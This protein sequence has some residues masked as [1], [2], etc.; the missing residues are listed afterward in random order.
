MITWCE[1]ASEL[2]WNRFPPW[3]LAVSVRFPSALSTMVQRPALTVA[4]Q[5]SGPPEA[6]TLTLPVGAP[7]AVVTVN[8]TSTPCPGC[9][10]SGYRRRCCVVVGAAL[11]SIGPEVTEVKPAAAKI[12]RCLP[13]APV[14]P[15]LVNVARPLASV[16]C[17]AVPIKRA[18]AVPYRRRH[19]HAGGRHRVPG[20][21]AHLDHG[22]PS[23]WDAHLGVA[24]RL[25]DDAERR[26][27]SRSRRRLEADR[28]GTLRGSLD[29][30]LPTR[31]PRVHAVDARPSLAVLLVRG[32]T[33][34]PPL[35]TRQVTVTPAPG[36]PRR[37]SPGPPEGPPAW[38]RPDHPARHRRRCGC[39]PDL[40]PPRWR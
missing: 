31:E 3:K 27:G 2:D 28:A 1:S 19:R 8:T 13:L 16:V 21:V 6:V 15:R 14:M 7:P 37:R 18:G 34:P 10:G 35:S 39:P 17:V 22:L 38:C 20:R 24:R 33:E 9:D 36:C 4:L 12:S 5:L 11:T 32:V 40:R 29:L 25:G 23:E 26:R 30:L